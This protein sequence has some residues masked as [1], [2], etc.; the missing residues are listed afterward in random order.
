VSDPKLKSSA[1]QI[2]RE[3]PNTFIEIPEAVD[4]SEFPLY[5]PI[6]KLEGNIQCTGEAEYVDDINVWLCYNLSLKCSLSKV[7]INHLTIYCLLS[8]R[9]PRENCMPPMLSL[10]META[11]LILAVLMPLKP[12]WV[13]ELDRTVH[14]CRMDMANI[15]IVFKDGN[16][17]KIWRYFLLFFCCAL[18]LFNFLNFQVVPFQS[19]M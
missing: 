9:N 7:N 17:H 5:E 6:K 10:N 2:T 8:Y 18:T 3:V 14:Q 19:Y 13:L 15:F 11:V 4:P 16:C 1:T 12:W